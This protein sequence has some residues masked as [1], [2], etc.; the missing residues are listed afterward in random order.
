MKMATRK[1]G[2]SAVTFVF[3]QEAG[4]VIARLE[5]MSEDMVKQ[6]ATHGLNQKIGDSFAGA[7]TPQSAYERAQDTLDMLL[8][9]KWVTGKKTGGTNDLVEALHRETGEPIDLCR[10]KLAGASKEMVAKFKAHPALQKH[11]AAIGAERAMAK[12]KAAEEKARSQHEEFGTDL[13]GLFD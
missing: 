7:L 12:A 11:L 13:S 9:G 8:D 3:E 2:D 4:E 6:L 10:E 5:D 1:K